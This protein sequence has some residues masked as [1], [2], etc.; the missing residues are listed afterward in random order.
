MIIFYRLGILN[1]EIIQL[2][3]ILYVILISG[4]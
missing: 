4:N 3:L 2:S 1:L